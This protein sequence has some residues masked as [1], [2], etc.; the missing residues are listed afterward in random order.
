MVFTTRL[1]LLHPIL[2][3]TDTGTGVS[4]NRAPS[5]GGKHRRRERDRARAGGAVILERHVSE[6]RNQAARW[7]GRDWRG[8]VV[9]PC[10]LAG[11]PPVH[12]RLFRSRARSRRRQPRAV[13]GHTGPP[14]TAASMS[15]LE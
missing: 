9:G 10:G 2:H 4:V 3:G 12:R 14:R 11:A 1:V 15:I 5:G 6:Q 13:V 8:T 7:S